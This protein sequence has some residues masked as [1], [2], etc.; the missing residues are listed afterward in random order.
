MST[1]TYSIISFSQ[2]F[3]LHIAGNLSTYLIYLA[4][5]NQLSFLLHFNLVSFSKLFHTFKPIK[6]GYPIFTQI[7]SACKV[8]HL[9]ILPFLFNSHINAIFQAYINHTY[10]STI[11][12]SLE[13]SNNFQPLTSPHL[14]SPV[15]VKTTRATWPTSHQPDRV[16]QR[17]ST[18]QASAYSA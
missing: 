2:L 13:F 9:S 1:V 17:E 5:P 18:M 12:Y 7:Q 10:Q 11:Q 6:S 8:F 4:L 15:I 3:R 14:N 16:H